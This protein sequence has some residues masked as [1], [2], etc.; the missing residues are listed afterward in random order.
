MLRDRLRW[1]VIGIIVFVVIVFGIWLAVYIR[2]KATETVQP[3]VTTQVA[4]ASPVDL[5]TSLHGRE[6]PNFTL[7]DQ[8]G[9]KISLSQYRGKV[10]ILAF[11]DSEC[12]TICPLTTV[13]MMDALKLLGPEAEKH[14]QLLGVNANPTA[15]SVSDVRQYSSEH[16]MMDSW[17]FLTG[18]DNQLNAV[19]KNY[20]IYDQIVGG[21]ID[22]TPALYII[23]PKGKEQVL[24]MTSSQYS[25]VAAEGD[26][27]AQQVARFLPTGVN[28]KIPRINDQASTVGSK[29][30]IRMPEITA[31]GMTGQV[32]IGPGKP[33]LV[34][35]FASWVP[36]IQSDLRALNKYAEM[37]NHPDVVAV[38]VVPTEPSE[39]AVKSTLTSLPLLH[40]KVGLDKSGQISD[41]YQV[42]DLMWLSL[43][44]GKGHIIW[45]QDGW[46]T[47]AALG[48][49]VKHALQHAN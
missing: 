37:P 16:Q 9:K 32:T 42:S 30:V 33:Q 24:F 29:N 34:V 47:I 49:S 10:V 8:S 41:A 44:D 14:V 17:H 5:G 46:T 11:V 48:K 35:F 2:S 36:Q 45:S 38:D 22:H 27:L 26:V 1:S 21:Q 23:D 6:A 31:E 18:S 19:W 28:P 4:D 13:S 40:Y 39:N 20:Y 25:S 15:N 43:T 7:T 3:T 12:T